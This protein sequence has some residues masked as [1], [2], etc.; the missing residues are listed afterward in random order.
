MNLI[1]FTHHS[2]HSPLFEISKKFTRYQ[3]LLWVSPMKIP[4]FLLLLKAYVKILFPFALNTAHFHKNSTH[5][6]LLRRHFFVNPSPAL[7]FLRVDR[8]M[9]GESDESSSSSPT[10]LSKGL[11]FSSSVRTTKEK[12]KH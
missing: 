9:T 12:N 4:I 7:R 3:S 5:L 2:L 1:K 10:S 11:L 6:F 8:T